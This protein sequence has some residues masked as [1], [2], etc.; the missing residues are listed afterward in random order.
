MIV[1]GGSNGIG[2]SAAVALAKQGAKI[3][4]VCRDAARA[5]AAAE[6]VSRVGSAPELV[7]ADLSSMAE[8]RKAATRLLELC[9]KIDVLVNNA[10]AMNQLRETTADGY[11]RT[12]AT[13]H[14]AY[15]LL[16]NLLL[17]RLKASG[18]SRVISVSSGAH[19]KAS[20][21]MPFD[22]LHA[23][24]GYSSWDA[25]GQSKLANILFTRELARRL[26]GTPVVANAMHPGIVATGFG[27]NTSGPLRMAI[28]AFQ[29][30]ML[31]PD[32]GAD[33]IV[34]LASAPE[35]ASATGKYFVKRREQAPQA[36]ALDDAAARK[37]WDVSARLT[38]LA[39]AA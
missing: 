3:V 32:Q 23:E 29:F 11:E 16:T 18:A 19:R 17:E 26:E 10:G 14:L 4:L 39:A 33:T 37:L 38:G 25:Y 13:N 34:W 15:F 28:R 35:A 6:E 31:T 1:T 12:F 9:P 7:L 2:K 20:K 8:V 5:K 24:R 22:D 21:G 36:Q 30:F 27:L